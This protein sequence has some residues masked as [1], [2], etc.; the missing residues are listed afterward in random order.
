MARQKRQFRLI[1]T[2]KTGTGRYSLESIGR[3]QDDFGVIKT[4]AQ[5]DEIAEFITKLGMNPAYIPTY[6][7]VGG[8]LT[9]TDG[10]SK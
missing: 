7:K 5:K 8:K 9:I 3:G 6:R 2:T 4:S 10:V 1:I